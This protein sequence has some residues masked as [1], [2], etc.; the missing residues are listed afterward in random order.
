MKQGIKLFLNSLVKYKSHYSDS[1]RTYFHPRLT[2]KLIYDEFKKNNINWKVSR[3]FFISELNKF[4]VKIYVPKKDTC[5]T[6]DEVNAK[7]KSKLDEKTRIALKTADENHKDR[8]KVARE[9]LNGKTNESKNSDNKVLVF[10]FDLQRTLPLPYINTSVT[11]YKRQLWLYNLGINLRCKNKGF[12][13]IWNESEG[14]RG[15]N[16]IMSCIY[17]FLMNSISLANY[18]KIH[19]F[20]DGCAGQNRN[21]T[22]IS[23]MSYIV[24]TTNISEWTH[25]FMESGHSF[26]PNDTDFGRI[27][28]AKK[29]ALNIF[30]PNEYKDL[31]ISCKFSVTPMV[32][33][34]FDF[35]Q[36]QEKFT[37]RKNNTDGDRFFIS[38]VKWMRI[39]K[40]SSKV[41]QYKLSNSL[42]EQAKN[43]D[44]SKRSGSSS[45]FSLNIEPLYAVPNK[46]SCEKFKDLQDLMR[47]IPE[48]HQSFY[49]DLPHEA[50]KN[51]DNTEM[52]PDIEEE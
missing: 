40:F 20:S 33:K 45:M 32:G 25:S 1:D 28:R 48:V 24:E 37:F 12:M 5:S 52:L 8:A 11:F 31:M 3:S 41:L 38:K 49:K 39:S 16:E 9:L 29:R 51:K 47:F 21:K 13:F 2:Q 50:R 18:E 15:S 22:M 36:I 34:M 14:K 6:C 42:N 44:F 4:N 10:T 26:L 35:A 19:T 43:F 7:L 46:I 23:F 17:D 27:E 30:S